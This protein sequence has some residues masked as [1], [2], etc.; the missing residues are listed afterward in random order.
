MD[1][2]YRCML[3]AGL[4]IAGVNGEV[5]PGQWEYQVGIARGIEIGD[6]MWLA[7]YIVGRVGEDFDVDVDFEPK[8]VLGDWNGSGCHTNFS[9]KLCREEGGLDYMKN[10][11]F[12]ALAKFHKECIALYGEG[13]E[14]RL[15][16]THETSSMDEFSW[17]ERSRGAS[18][19]VP[20]YTQ[21]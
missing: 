7:R 17:K 15:T 19:R 12:P 3:Y 4:K 16:G 11:C 10:H 6:H 1:R 5:A 21:S 18:I 2:A 20:V 8:P 13:N 14:H 9:T